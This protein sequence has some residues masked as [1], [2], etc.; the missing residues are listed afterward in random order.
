MQNFLEYPCPNCSAELNFD[1]IVKDLKCNHCNSVIPIEKK[2][3]TIK[4]KDISGFLSTLVNPRK[5]IEIIL[6][7]CSKCGKENEIKENTPSFECINCGNNVVNSTAF[8]LQPINPSGLIPFSIS[9]NEIQALFQNWVNKGFWTSDDFRKISVLDNLRGIY[10]PFWTFDAQT[11][12]QWSGQAGEYYYKTETYTDSEGNSK[13]EKVQHTRWHYRSGHYS[14]FFNDILIC[15]SD[16]ISHS[17][18]SKIFPFNLDEL[19]PF[20]YKYLTGWESD[21][22]SPEIK[23]C[24]DLSKSIINEKIYRECGNLCKIDT[25]TDLSLVT[26]FENESYKHI[27]L[28]VWICTYVYKN[29]KY[30]FSINGQNGKI[31]GNKPISSTKVGLVILLVV[32]L[33]V[34]IL[35]LL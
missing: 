34:A 18:V 7:A 29:K 20:D 3:E 12:T 33:L 27:L 14:K 35:F 31:D 10:V 8:Q 21:T 22:Y 6:Y 1:P 16:E 19:V 17:E 25:Y 2:L 11:E 4:E 5:D 28:P 24:Y 26:A 15:G 13:E 9:K 30:N 32:V 23:K